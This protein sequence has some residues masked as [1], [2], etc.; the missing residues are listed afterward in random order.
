MKKVRK[1]RAK[2]ESVNRWKEKNY[3]K[4]VKKMGEKWKWWI[5]PQLG[6]KHVTDDKRPLE[7]FPTA[8]TK[9]KPS[10]RLAKFWQK[11]DAISYLVTHGYYL[12]TRQT[13]QK[14]IGF[15]SPLW[16]MDVKATQICWKWIIAKFHY[17]DMDTTSR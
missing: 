6:W 12:K 4:K 9:L 2:G 7:T 10:K 11:I 3:V 17:H 5:G 1:K 15:L 16:Y 13:V 14:Y 8:H